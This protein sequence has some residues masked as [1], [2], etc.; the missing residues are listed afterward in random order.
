MYLYYIIVYMY[1]LVY[2]YLEEISSHCSL[3]LHN[4]QQAGTDSVHVFI[5]RV[6][7]SVC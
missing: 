3:L 6:T 5:D 1:M 4:S 2:T 7:N